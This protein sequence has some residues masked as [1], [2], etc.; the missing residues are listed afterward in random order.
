[1]LAR[2]D[3]VRQQKG[4]VE[5]GEIAPR[6]RSSYRYNGGLGWAWRYDLV[7]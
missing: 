5:H 1:M 7:G 4:I 6:R 3:A 2:D